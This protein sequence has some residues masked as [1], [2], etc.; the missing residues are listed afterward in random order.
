MREPN[1]TWLGI[2]DDSVSTVAKWLGVGF[3][4]LFAAMHVL[5]VIFSMTTGFTSIW[6]STVEKQ[7]CF[8]G[9]W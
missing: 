2:I 9:P 7:F 5:M 1:T 6:V 8:M 4:G 3:W